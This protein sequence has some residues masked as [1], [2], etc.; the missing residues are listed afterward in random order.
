M[1]GLEILAALIC[2]AAVAG[3][4]YGVSWYNDNIWGPKQKRRLMESGP[5]VQLSQWG[6][7]PFNNAFSGELIGG[8][9]SVP[10][11]FV[12]TVKDYAVEV[13]YG[14]TGKPHLIVRVFFGPVSRDYDAIMDAWHKQQG[15]V[16]NWKFGGDF[17][18][19][20][21]LF[22]AP[23]YID[24]TLPY[25][26]SSPK[27]SKLMMLAERITHELQLLD[28]APLEYAAACELAADVLQESRR[29]SQNAGLKS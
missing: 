22:C 6:F 20:I 3:L 16:A 2:L 23:V 5:L 7:K 19:P 24:A 27:A 12:G 11:A 17:F 29:R 13:S 14:W 28:R 26:A 18:N 25:S 4:H 8:A 21:V 10:V 9:A 15:I 1:S